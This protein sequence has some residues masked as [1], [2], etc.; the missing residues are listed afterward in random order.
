MFVFDVL[1]LLQLSYFFQYQ[2]FKLVTWNENLIYL[3]I[4]LKKNVYVKMHKIEK[5]D[6]RIFW[7]LHKYGGGCFFKKIKFDCY[8]AMIVFEMLIYPAKRT[9]NPDMIF[10]LNVSVKYLYSLLYK[11]YMYIIQM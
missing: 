9:T 5:D 8:S 7:L 1:V 10:N 2:L 4:N 3:R 11:T 6:Y